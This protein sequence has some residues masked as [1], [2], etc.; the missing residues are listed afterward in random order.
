[1]KKLLCLLLV[2]V[3]LL[4]CGCTADKSEK[5]DDILQEYLDNIEEYEIHV[6]EYGN[7]VSHIAMDEKL[8]IGIMYPE[9]EAAFLNKAINKWVAD[10]VREYTEQVEAAPEGTS[11]AELTFSYESFMADDSTVSIVMKG[12]FFAPYMA[13]PEDLVKVFNA[14]LK[15]KRV[16][17]VD[18]LF[19]EKGLAEFIERV[20]EKT[21]VSSKDVDEH[22]L[23]NSYLTKE[24]LIVVL[25]RGAYLPMSEGTKTVVFEYSD[26][27]ALLRKSFDE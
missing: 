7:P 2:A 27:A 21:G 20:Q 18:T 9:T 11:G 22:F 26:L 3:L 8:M 23:D 14:D 6:R 10:I 12:T 4:L 19:S 17:T 5:P 24:N 16:F 15:A 13:H 1:M 25:E